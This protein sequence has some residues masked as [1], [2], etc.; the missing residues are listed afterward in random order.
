[1]AETI[2]YTLNLDTTQMEQS[3]VSTNKEIQ[4]LNASQK[5]LRKNGEASS[6]EF[7]DNAEKLKVLKKSYNEQSKAIQNTNKAKS[8]EVGHLERLKAELSLVTSNVNKLSKA[9]LNDV[10]VGGKMIAK[11]KALT[12]ELVKS[13]EAGG[14]FHREVGKYSKGMAQMGEGAQMAGGM[15]GSF[16]GSMGKLPGL[17]MNAAKATKVFFTMLLSNPIGLILTAIAALVGVAWSVL[18]KFQPVL[19]WVEDKLGYLSGLVDGFV[20]SLKGIGDVI[21]AVFSGDFAKAGEL[22]GD[23]G[24]K[25]VAV[26]EAQE[27][28]TKTLRD[29]ERQQKL[30]DATTAEAT[31][32]MKELEAAY[33]D[34]GKTAE[35]R[36]KA[37]TELTKMKK[38]Q[39]EDDYKVTK[40]NLEGQLKL[41]E[42]LYGVSLKNATEV[43]KAFDD[44]VI[45]NVD[46]YNK[47]LDMIIKN[48]ETH[49]KVVEVV[50][51]AQKEQSRIAI[52]G[53]SENLKLLKAQTKYYEETHK[54]ILE[55]QK[56]LT[57]EMIKSEEDRINKIANNRINAAA[58]ELE[59]ARTTYK[60]NATLMKEAELKFATEKI[61]IRDEANKEI[62]K[63]Y[64]DF[65]KQELNSAKESLDLI[66]QQNVNDLKDITI[67]TE[68]E[69]S[70]RIELHT[71][72]KDKQLALV[73][74]TAKAEGW[75]KTKTATELLKVEQEYTDKVIKLQKSLL[76]NQKLTDEQSIAQKKAVDDIILGIH[77]TYL[78]SL[79]LSNAEQLQKELD[80]IDAKNAAII[81]KLEE[82]A[83]KEDEQLRAKLD[84]K[85]ITEEEYQAIKD[86]R[87]IEIQT[88]KDEAEAVRDEEK[89]NAKQAALEEESEVIKDIAAKG[90]GM[91]QQLNQM[92]IDDANRLKDERIA[93]ATEAANR[94]TEILQN[95]FNV[96]QAAIQ[97]SFTT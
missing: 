76:D 1:M 35:E 8:E 44:G 62:Q 11:Q 97:Y 48:E 74:E 6:K 92:A 85:L 69:L 81:A 31:A 16:G 43:K 36:T 57:K 9:E 75:S 30:N 63:N 78:E 37:L 89:K 55:D 60:D 77:K 96:E 39:A 19:D 40:N 41:M 22:I 5:D 33:R 73:N 94:E 42:S 14:N 38:E 46:E 72:I 3:L 34:T 13:E 26:A 86:A 68:D 59:I 7:V 82:Q 53:L 29:G 54:S 88:A 12:D 66:K 87:D 32:K 95:K 80:N 49:A 28:L 71:S 83:I 27:N 4:E 18:K 15:M 17:I 64:D 58:K 91:L 51:Q 2:T 25:M 93:A 50:A 47:T 79:D 70:K 67:Q 52:K 21:A 20:E 24:D 84:A 45:S 65:S 56:V 23:M 10:K 61:K 90:I